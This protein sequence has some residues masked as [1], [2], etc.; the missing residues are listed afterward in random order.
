MLGLGLCY[1]AYQFMFWRLLL[2]VCF[3]FDTLLFGLLHLFHQWPLGMHYF[4]VLC[5]FVL[6][7]SVL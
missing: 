1:I 3:K 7:A 5:R 4:W 2:T 6:P